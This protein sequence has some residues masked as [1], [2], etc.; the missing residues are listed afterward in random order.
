MNS[1][2]LALYLGI[3]FCSCNPKPQPEKDLRTVKSDFSFLIGQ[4]KV[5]T[6]I[7]DG[8]L[9]NNDDRI[10]FYVKGQNAISSD[11]YFNRGSAKNPSYG[12]GQY[13]FGF[14]SVSRSWSTYFLTEKTAR[15]YKGS[16]EDGEWWFYHTFYKP[17]GY[18]VNQRHVWRPISPDRMERI[19]QSLDHNEPR[20]WVTFHH[21]I[22]SRF[23]PI[24]QS[25]RKAD[26]KD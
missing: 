19:M 14:D 13:H 12:I 4:W 6:L 18:E 2:H 7:N 3:L 10:T 16:F 9:L 1:K 24:T 21:T 8:I 20:D 22:F 11:W 5:D 17:S 15:F 26:E 25:N 23:P